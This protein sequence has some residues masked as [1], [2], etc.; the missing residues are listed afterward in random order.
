MTVGSM[1]IAD[2]TRAA[3]SMAKLLFATQGS[4][5]QMAI[6]PFTAQLRIA[7]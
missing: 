7:P 3:T 4:T 6:T 1:S 5:Y 2:I